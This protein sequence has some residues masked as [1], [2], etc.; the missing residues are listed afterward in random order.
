MYLKKHQVKQKINFA[1]FLKHYGSFCLK[2]DKNETTAALFQIDNFSDF[3][4]E[5]RGGEKQF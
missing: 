2:F 5:V 3:I 1:G 4:A